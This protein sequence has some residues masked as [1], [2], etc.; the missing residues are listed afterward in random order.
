MIH[1]TLRAFIVSMV[2]LCTLNTFAASVLEFMH[3]SKSAIRAKISETAPTRINFGGYQITEVIGDENKYKIITDSN[4]LNVFI[5]PKVASG[6][7]IP[8]TLIAGSNKVQD[9]LLEVSAQEQLP[10]SIVIASDSS[11]KGEN[12][13]D[14][15]EVEL[16][17]RAMLDCDHTQDKYYITTVK[18]KLTIPSL[19]KL[20]I[21][22]DKTWRFKKLTGAS[23]VITNKDKVTARLQG[24]HIKSLFEGA[25]LTVIENNLL[26]KGASTKAFIVTEEEE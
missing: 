6:S 9:L 14:K 12:L 3:N 5:T 18:R 19:P 25:K 21:V 20:S 15:S 24:K 8:I 1:I 2:F 7:V 23:L 10:R 17:L 4:G 26:V 13:S 11:H 22:Q 16:L